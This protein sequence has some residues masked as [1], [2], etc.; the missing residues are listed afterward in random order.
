M[1]NPGDDVVLVDAVSGVT[2]ILGG[3]GDDEVTVD[4]LP[5]WSAWKADHEYTLSIDI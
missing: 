2:N 3:P 4:Q 1:T 5:S